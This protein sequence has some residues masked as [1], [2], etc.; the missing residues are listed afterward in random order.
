[1]NLPAS[2]T[3]FLG[4][5]QGLYFGREE[6]FKPHTATELPLIHVHCFA[7]K[8]EDGRATEEICDTIEK[9]LGIRLVPGDMHVE[10]QVF[11]HNVRDVA[12]AKS[13]FCASFRLPRKVAF[14]KVEGA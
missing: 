14:A 11:I 5:Y 1:M 4:N 8:S 3:D 7:V 6:L 10:G 13:M 9:Q 12:P 2:A